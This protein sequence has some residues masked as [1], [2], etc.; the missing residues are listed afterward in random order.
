MPELM[1]A[2]FLGHGNPMNAISTNSYTESWRRIGAQI[3]KPKA[4]LAISAHWYVPETSVTISSMPKTIHDFGGFPPELYRVQYPAPGDPQLARR[5]QQLLAP[6]PVNLDD[7]WGL[8]HGTWS[9]LVHVYPKAEIPVVQLSINETEPASFHFELGKKLAPLRNEGV[10]VVGS[11][12][13]VHNLHTYA[14]GRHL[15][16]P[17]DWAV[18]FESEARQMMLAGD[19]EPLVRY[20][21]LGPEAKLSIPTPDHYL[22]LLYVLATR[23]PGESITFPVEGIDGGSISMLSV[24]VGG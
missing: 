23:Q 4:I 5:V 10:L 21:R 17:Y 3:T 1:P 19:F 11:G 14:W 13:L 6:L 22:P 16:E 9:V 15:P 20:E 2:I 7:S 12:N 18:K 24:C 8:D